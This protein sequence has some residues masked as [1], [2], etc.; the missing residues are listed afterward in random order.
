MTKS[1]E[2]RTG[3]RIHIGNPYE[4]EYLKIHFIGDILM[5]RQEEIG[6]HYNPGYEICIITNGKGIFKIEDISYPINND[7]IFITKATQ[8][9]GGWPSKEEPYRI[10]YMCFSINDANNTGVDALFWRG[11]NE[12]LKSIG[13]PLSNERFQMKEVHRRMMREILEEGEYSTLQ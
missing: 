4:D 5:R 1:I 7:Q 12:K 2:D 9:H 11:I 3:Q 6:Y 8:Y 13:M 10:L